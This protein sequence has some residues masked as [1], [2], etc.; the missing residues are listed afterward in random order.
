MIITEQNSLTDTVDFIFYNK[1][2]RNSGAVRGAE[3]HC[4]FANWS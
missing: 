2:N 4:L 1:V 3:L